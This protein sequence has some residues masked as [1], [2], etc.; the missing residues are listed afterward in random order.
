MLAILFSM[1]R[2]H[3]TG[4]VKFNRVNFS[5]QLL[6]RIKDSKITK[7]DAVNPSVKYSLASLF[8]ITVSTEL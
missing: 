5:K 4:M 1:F 7:N 3:E 8:F 6:S 2:L